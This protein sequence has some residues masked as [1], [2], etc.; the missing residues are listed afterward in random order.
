MNEIPLAGSIE[1]TGIQRILIHLNRHRKSGT[2]VIKTPVFTKKVFVVK[3]DA[4]FASSTYEDD[5]LGEML[6]KAGKITMEQ[7]DKSVELLK[8]TGKRQGAILVELG[9]LTPKDL[10]W[11]VKYQVREIIYSL[12][13]LE[14]AG[15]EFIDGVIPSHEVITL[16]MSIGN[17]IYEGIKRID[18]WTRIKN[19]MPA[20]DIVLKLSSDP[21]SIYQDVELSQQDR[22][23]LS[24]VDGRKTIKEIIDNA[25]MGSFEAMKTLYVLFSIGVLE[26][27]EKEPETAKTTEPW[28]DIDLEEIL[29][30]VS[31]D[32]DTLIRKIDEMYLKIDFKSPEELLDVDES[33]DEDTL[34]KHYHRLTREFHPDRY[35]SVADPS[36]KDKLT[37]VFDAINQAYAILSES[38][39]KAKPAVAPVAEKKESL[40]SKPDTGKIFKQGIEELK[41]GNFNNAVDLLSSAVD[42]E[43]G[44]AKYRSY[45]ALAL[46]KLPNRTRDAENALIE[47]IRLEPDCADHYANLGLVYGREGL[48]NKARETFEKALKLDRE[49]IKAKKGIE[50]L[51]G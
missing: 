22:K 43:P 47:A 49:N 7:Y 24:L 6:L 26:E 46:T 40:P 9:F 28:E 23:M 50:N 1:E 15:Y 2:L 29:Q 27:K 20:T 4:V 18:N 14:T 31:E 13:L 51:G 44:N 36:V 17:L 11:G 10:F 48:I 25:W 42:L 12:F 32:E 39:K 5:R 34:K 38:A 45:L 33:A 16:K 37:A 21:A 3:G 19:E 30:P 35:F 41:K 8:K